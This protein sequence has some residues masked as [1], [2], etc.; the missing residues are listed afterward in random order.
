MTES[1]YDE[2]LP[3]GDTPPR[4][5]EGERRDRLVA[6][7]ALARSLADKG[8]DTEAYVVLADAVEEFLE[9]EELAEES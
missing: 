4:R 2:V 5:T 9:A 7:F 3:M 1:L 6:A 8:R